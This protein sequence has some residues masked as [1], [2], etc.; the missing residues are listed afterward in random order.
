MKVFLNVY[1][2]RANPGWRLSDDEADEVRR[3][4]RDLPD[5]P[6]GPSEKLGYMGFILEPSGD[7]VRGP[8]IEVRVFGGIVSSYYEDGHSRHKMDSEALELWLLEMARRKGY[9]RLLPQTH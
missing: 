7:D 1:S 5:S 3:R 9:G 2:G 4:L 6:H 8:V